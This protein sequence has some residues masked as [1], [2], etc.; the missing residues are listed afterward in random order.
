MNEDTDKI[1]RDTGKRLENL[2]ERDGF[3]PRLVAAH[4]PKLN[5][6]KIYRWL[7]SPDFFAPPLKDCD[8]ILDLAVKVEKVKNDFSD[9]V[10]SW[11]DDRY[12][13]ITMLGLFSFAYLKI[14][15]DKNLSLDAKIKK[16]TLLVFKE[17]ARAKEKK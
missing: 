2:V 6:K 12:S 1:R 15:E 11:N 7:G 9:I 10:I 8:G 3:S 4:I 5:Y 16:L 13:Q 17:W 14:L